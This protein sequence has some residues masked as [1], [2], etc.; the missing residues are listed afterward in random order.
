MTADLSTLSVHELS[1]GL[2]KRRFTPVD[3]TEACLKRITALEP[4]LHAF[5]TVYPDEA[6]LAAEAEARARSVFFS[7]FEENSPD[8]AS[9]SGRRGWRS[10]RPRW[11][12]G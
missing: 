1:A 5:V 9:A 6:R 7:L 3:I 10:P 2:A 4:K 11:S 8:V 12:A